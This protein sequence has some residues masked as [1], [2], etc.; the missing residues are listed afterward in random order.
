MHSY[1]FDCLKGF[2]WTQHTFRFRHT[3]I[4]MRSIKIKASALPATMI[5]NCQTSKLNIKFDGRVVVFTEVEEFVT[6]FELELVSSWMVVVWEVEV[7]M[8]LLVI[9]NELN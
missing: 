3:Q 2:L 8:V 6:R 4:T 5:E 7:I 1:K 9:G